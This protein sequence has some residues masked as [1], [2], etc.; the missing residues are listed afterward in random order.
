MTRSRTSFW[1]TAGDEV[2]VAD[3]HAMWMVKWSLQTLAVG[4][5]PA[6][7]K[8]AWPRVWRWIEGLP[9][10][11]EKGEAEQIEPDKAKEV[12]L[13]SDYIAKELVVDP[14]DPLGLESGA[15]VEVE[16]SDAAPGTYPQ[17]GKLVGLTVRE[18]V[19]ELDNGLRL[20]FPRQGYVV[21]KV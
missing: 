14:K 21:K 12:L 7:S 5:D 11:D 1:R 2:G 9:A 3:I 10:H 15:S 6:F 20:H 8:E 17:K 16:A 19:V 18:A 13:G 4:Q